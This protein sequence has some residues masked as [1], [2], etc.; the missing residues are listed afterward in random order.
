MCLSVYVWAIPW[1]AVLTKSG[2]GMAL[3]DCMD[4]SNANDSGMSYPR[5]PWIGTLAIDTD[6]V[7]GIRI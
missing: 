1:V 4:P 2:E 5:V 6:Y 7:D 3:V